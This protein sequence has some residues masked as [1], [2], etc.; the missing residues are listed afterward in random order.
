MT[1]LN[2]D[3]LNNDYWETELA[4]VTDMVGTDRMMVSNIKRAIEMGVEL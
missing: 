1:A 4:L 3:I 2:L